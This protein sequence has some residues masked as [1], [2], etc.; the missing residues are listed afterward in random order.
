MS[1]CCERPPETGFYDAG[2]ELTPV[3]PERRGPAAIMGAERRVISVR[4]RS[5]LSAVLLGNIE[6]EG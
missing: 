5:A 2:G 4:D 6:N 3:G 1:G